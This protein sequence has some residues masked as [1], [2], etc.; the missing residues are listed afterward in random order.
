MA[1]SVKWGTSVVERYR[2]RYPRAV[3]I[4]LEKGGISTRQVVAALILGAPA[5]EDFKKIV[6]M[7]H[8]GPW[9]TLAPG[10]V[11]LEPQLLGAI[12]GLALSLE[13]LEI[14]RAL[15]TAKQLSLF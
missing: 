4:V 12:G 2:Q 15:D 11:V 7:L 14:C 1:Y 10:N 13:Q 9:R 3:Q 5:W 8:L 6:K